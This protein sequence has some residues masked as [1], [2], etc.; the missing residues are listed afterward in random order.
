MGDRENS[1]Y[2]DLSNKSTWQKSSQFES[3]LTNAM[4]SPPSLRDLYNHPSSAW[5]FLPAA[6]TSTSTPSPSPSSHSYEWKTS[7]PNPRSIFDLSPSQ[8]L[9]DSGI[10]V[11]LLLSSLLASAVLQYTSTAIVMPWEVGRLLLQVQWVP[12]DTGDPAPGSD[13]IAE[14]EDEEVCILNSRALKLTSTFCE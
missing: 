7:R 14:E 3:T 5:A 12:R 9:S 10:D 11:S 2:L 6:N 13:E 8:D 4:N 1:I